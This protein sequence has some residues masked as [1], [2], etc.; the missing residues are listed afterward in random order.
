MT[1]SHTT[2]R[3]AMSG[4]GD[5]FCFARAKS[6]QGEIFHCLSGSAG[7]KSNADNREESVRR[8]KNDDN[9]VQRRRRVGKNST[10][11]TNSALPLSGSFLNLTVSISRE[12]RPQ[13]EFISSMGCGVR[14]QKQK[15]PHSRFQNATEEPASVCS[16]YNYF[17]IL[18]MC[19]RLRTLGLTC[20]LAY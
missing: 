19:A 11:S 18:A 9:S 6:S 17:Y 4:T 1:E 2:S 5:A 13:R 16:T 14:S 20:D 10:H 7:K 15:K 3:L 12:K 8:T